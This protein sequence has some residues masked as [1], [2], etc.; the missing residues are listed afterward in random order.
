MNTDHPRPGHR[1]QLKALWQEAFGDDMG[2]IDGFFAAAYSPSRCLCI[3]T[4]DAVLAAAYWLDCSYSGGKLAYIYAVATAREHRGRGLCHALLQQLHSCLAAQGYAGAVLVPGEEGLDRLYR[5]MGYEFFGGVQKITCRAAAAPVALRQV[6]AMEYLRL[7]QKFLPENGVRQPGENLRL[8]QKL[9]T[10]A[11]GEDF[12]LAYSRRE[13]GLW[14]LELLGNAA[15][16]PG[17][18]RALGQEKGSFRIPGRESFAMYRPL[19]VQ[20][21]PAYFGLAFD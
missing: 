4:A 6:S 20:E 12:V 16:A 17:I 18:L 10:L 11:A 2:F 1:P 7:R 5:S 13:E 15:A 19:T 8:L 9:A 3:Y 21:P 14:G